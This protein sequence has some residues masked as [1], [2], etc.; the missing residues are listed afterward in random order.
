MAGQRFQVL[1]GIVKTA[2]Q[3][4]TARRLL[5]NASVCSTGP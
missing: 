4:V 2:G 3:R 1:F 5:R